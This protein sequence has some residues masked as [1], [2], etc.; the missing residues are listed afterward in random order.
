MAAMAHLLSQG[1]LGY[2]QGLSYQPT[3]FNT[4]IF[5]EVSFSEGSVRYA[6]VHDLSI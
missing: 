6:K 5:I 2:D 1:I 3:G 4:R